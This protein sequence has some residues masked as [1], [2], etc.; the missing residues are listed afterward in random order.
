MLFMV[1]ALKSE[2]QAFVDLYRLNKKRLG[3]YTLFTNESI[4]LI[5]SGMGIENSKNA[6]NI[7]I[8]NFTIRDSDI[9]LNIGICGANKAFEIGELIEINSI[10]Y[11]GKIFHINTKAKN[12]ITCMDTEASEDI[13]EIVDMESYGFYEACKSHLELLN[14]HMFKV[15]SDYFEPRTVTKDKTKKLIFEQIDAMQR[16]IKI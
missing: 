14:I 11:D 5:V 9:L 7:L 3:V 13:C 10:I 1:I 6:T 12:V 16:A 8:Q 4:T 2:A 15:V